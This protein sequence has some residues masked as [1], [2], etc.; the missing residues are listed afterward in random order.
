MRHSVLGIILILY[1]VMSYEY[2]A[3]ISG[4]WHEFCFNSPVMREK[5]L[6]TGDADKNGK[7]GTGGPNFR[8]GQWLA[9]WP[10][11][12]LVAILQGKIAARPCNLD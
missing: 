8:R 6:T 2:F 9:L 5:R 11:Q 3:G 4:A 1:A 7:P 12:G 10:R